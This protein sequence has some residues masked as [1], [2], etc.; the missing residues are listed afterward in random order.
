MRKDWLK[1]NL[2][3]LIINLVVGLLFL[4]F[5][6][7]WTQN[8]LAIDAKFE[9]TIELVRQEGIDRKVKDRELNLLIDGKV[10]RIEFDRMIYTVNET[11][12]DVKYLLKISK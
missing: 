5:G 11:N 3:V 9:H 7:I 4:L 1:D 12:R 8:N 10:S 2:L 6:Y